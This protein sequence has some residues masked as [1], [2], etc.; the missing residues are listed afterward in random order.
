MAV[1]ALAKVKAD[2]EAKGTD[3]KTA[4]VCAFETKKWDIVYDLAYA[5][6]DVEAK[7][8][9]Q[10]GRCAGL[11]KLKHGSTCNQCQGSGKFGETTALV[12]AFGSGKWDIVA[13]L[14][15]L[16]ADV[17]V[18]DDKQRTAIMLATIKAKTG[19][20]EAL[21]E[22]NANMEARDQNDRTPLMLAAINRKTSTVEALMNLGADAEAEDKTGKTA[23]ALATQKGYSDV[24]QL[25][26]TTQFIHMVCD[27]MSQVK[28]ELENETSQV[29]SKMDKLQKRLNA[30]DRELATMLDPLDF[31]LLLAAKRGKPHTV[32]KLASRGANMNVTETK[33]TLLSGAV[34]GKSIKSLIY[35]LREEPDSPN[36]EERK[37]PLI[38]AIERGEQATA[39]A[40]VDGKAD[41]YSGI[42]WARQQKKY[43]LVSFL[44]SL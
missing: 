44:E 39:K 33:S 24:V 26:E 11:G 15:N 23:L 42:E 4:L 40:L 14:A 21:I 43:D 5:K 16:K 3:G 9:A 12:F 29:R 38:L 22:V 31:A 1:K 8:A 27:K 30:L 20:V 34:E 32:T 18:T 17:E 25:F 36:S 19:I 13:E 7:G 10:C 6:S 41:V 2:L 35:N 37:N 28:E